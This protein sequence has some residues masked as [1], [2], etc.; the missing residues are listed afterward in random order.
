MRFLIAAAALAAL[1]G[2]DTSTTTASNEAT[3]TAGGYTL[4]VRA[5]ET[6][7]SYIVT[8]PDG[9]QAATQVVDGMSTMLNADGI[10]A[11]GEMQAL[12]EGQ[13]E[14]FALRVPGVN[15]SVA[16]D[17]DNP[18]SESANVRINAGGRSVHVDAEEGGPGDGDDRANIRITGATESDA[19]D[20]IND[21]EGVSA[22]AKTQML[23]ALRLE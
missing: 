10:R 23:A 3:D 12:S 5:D 4:E 17:E 15:I 1:A 6:Q 14:V 7:R 8:A 21:A 16:A 11:L 9:G 2:C 20:F 13:P 18:N 19:R 22:E